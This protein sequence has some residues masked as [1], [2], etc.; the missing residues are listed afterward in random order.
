[1]CESNKKKQAKKRHTDKANSVFKM[2]LTM[3]RLDLA[4]KP[5]GVYSDVDNIF[6]VWQ[7]AN[8]YGEDE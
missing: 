1:M 4:K 5:T 3:R 7:F 6:D 2:L 8:L